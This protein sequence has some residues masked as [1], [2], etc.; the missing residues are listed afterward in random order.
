VINC[1]I[2]MQF[3]TLHQI[4]NPVTVTSPKIEIFRV[5]DGGESDLQ[6]TYIG[7][8]SAWL[9]AQDRSKCRSVVETAMLT[10][11]R[12]TWWWWWWNGT[13]IFRRPPPLTRAPNSGVV[14]RSLDSEPI[15]EFTACCWRCYQPGVVNTTSSDQPPSCKLWHFVGSKRRSLLMT[16]S[17]SVTPKTT[18]QHLI[19][20]SDKSVAYVTNNRDSIR[21]FVLLKLTTDRH[22]ASRGLFATAELLV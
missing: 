18:E 11:G 3:C 9:R 22:E 1:P 20:S 16:K 15:S 5:Q 2:L 13:A 17:F 8:K 6:P 4:L 7:L 14:G 21:R 10:T 19:A 12:A